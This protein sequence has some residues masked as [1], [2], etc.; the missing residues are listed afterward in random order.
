MLSGRLFG[1]FCSSRGQQQ[2]SR[3]VSVKNKRLY[4]LNSSVKKTKNCNITEI[5][6]KSFVIFILLGQC[7]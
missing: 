3:K 6:T 5:L 1:T 2:S 7:C 4:S